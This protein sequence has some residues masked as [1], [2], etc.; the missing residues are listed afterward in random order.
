MRQCAVGYHAAPFVAV[1]SV[2]ARRKRALAQRCQQGGR[3]ELPA[4]A[5][6]YLTADQSCAQR[7]FW[8]I[9]LDIKT[10]PQAVIASFYS[11]TLTINN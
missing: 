3:D 11:I 1:S 5:G 10:R 4:P 6:Y 7:P 9:V 2:S 8:K